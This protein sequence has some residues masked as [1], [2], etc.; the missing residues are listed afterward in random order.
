LTREQKEARPAV[1][2]PHPLRK[3]R[4]WESLHPQGW[5]TLNRMVEPRSL[6]W[7]FTIMN[8]FMDIG[9]ALVKGPGCPVS[10]IP[11]R[12]GIQYF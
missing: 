10:V 2:R 11:A 1:R 3:W 6:T 9:D 8:S 4:R 7:V 5:T 12:A